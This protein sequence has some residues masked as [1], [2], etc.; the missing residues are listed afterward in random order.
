[1]WKKMWGVPRTRLAHL[2]PLIHHFYWSTG[3]LNST[4]LVSPLRS[5]PSDPHPTCVGPL[6]QNRYEG[7]V[8]DAK[9]GAEALTIVERTVFICK[10]KIKNMNRGQELGCRARQG[11]FGGGLVE[12]SVWLTFWVVGIQGRQAWWGEAGKE[13]DGGAGLSKA[14]SK[15]MEP[16][17][18]SKG[19]P[20]GQFPPS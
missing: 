17:G 12:E 8:G 4:P 3:A 15:A 13:R 1:M 9:G 7:W 2:I 16:L 11:D 10:E 14:G 5:P 20:D 19:S 18:L 6:A